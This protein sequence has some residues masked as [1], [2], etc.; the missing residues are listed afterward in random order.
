[1]RAGAVSGNNE[2]TD[3]RAGGA[4]AKVGR[5]RHGTASAAG[6][7][8]CW[9]AAPTGAIA[10]GLRPRRRT[11]QR[12]LV[13]RT[14]A[15][16]VG[17]CRT[18]GR[19][20]V[21][22]GRRRPAGPLQQFLECRT[23]KCRSGSVSRRGNSF[24]GKL[25]GASGGGRVVTSHVVIPGPVGNLRRHCPRTHL[26]GSGLEGLFSRSSLQ[27]PARNHGFFQSSKL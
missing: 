16:V 12:H 7:A 20:S 21:P 9:R 1:M 19:S 2:C 26:I 14:E 13:V 8:E 15:E 11:P 3:I 25:R 17:R 6:T 23:A 22:L 10:S 18:P 5:A 24:A 4:R 27:F